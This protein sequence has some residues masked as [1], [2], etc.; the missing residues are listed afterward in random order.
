[1]LRDFGLVT[2]LEPRGVL[3]GVLAVLPAVLVLAERGELMPRP[4]PAR[5]AARCGRVRRP[6]LVIIVFV[7]ALLMFITFNTIVTESEGSKGLQAGDELPP[8]AMPLSTSSCRGPLRRERRHRGR[9][10]RRGCSSRLRGARA[11]RS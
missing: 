1:M 2:V 9:P 5:T 3:V 6:G 11:A 8:F 7:G 4:A 10:G